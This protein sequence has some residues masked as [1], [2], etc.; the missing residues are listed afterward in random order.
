LGSITEAKRHVIILKQSK[1]GDD[2]GLLAVLRGNGYLVESLDQVDF[3][4]D[5]AAVNVLAE[6]SSMLGKGYLSGTVMVLR[7]R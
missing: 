3:A 1:R 2:S 6:R 7:R 5:G 4:E